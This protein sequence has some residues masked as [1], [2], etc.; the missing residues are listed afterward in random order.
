M[1][2]TGANA[3][4]NIEQNEKKKR[5]EKQGNWK[6][7]FLEDGTRLSFYRKNK[8]FGFQSIPQLDY[9]EPNFSNLNLF[10]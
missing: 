3:G 6:R 4:R 10:Y 7:F 2:N 5:K 9:N 8:D 1:P